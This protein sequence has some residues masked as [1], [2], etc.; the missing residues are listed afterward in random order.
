MVQVEKE[1]MVQTFH[2]FQWRDD[3]L[4]VLIL[5]S[6]KSM[7]EDSLSRME[8]Y[9]ATAVDWVVDHDTVNIDIFISLY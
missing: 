5:K 8:T 2:V 9:L 4:D 6:L 7:E 1:L 3:G